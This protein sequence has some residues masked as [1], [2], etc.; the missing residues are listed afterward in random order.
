MNYYKRLVLGAIVAGVSLNAF[1]IKQGAFKGALRSMFFKL[2]RR[3]RK[4]VVVKL[5]TIE[6]NAASFSGKCVEIVSN[7]TTSPA[8]TLKAGSIVW[9]SHVET[10]SEIYNFEMV[11]L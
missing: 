6:V 5:N 2:W 8:S 7:T 1:C 4:S 11:M 9:L 10:L 3:L